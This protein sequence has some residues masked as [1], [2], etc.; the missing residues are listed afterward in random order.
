MT[1]EEIAD[2]DG[3]LRRIPPLHQP[4]HDQSMSGPD[5][6]ASLRPPSSA[7]SLR[8]GERGLSFHLQSSLELAG[9]PLSYGCPPGEPG[10]AVVRI[11][12]ARIR[13]LG[14]E[15]VA[16]GVP[17]HVLVLGLADRSRS[18]QRRLQKD[19]AKSAR[20]I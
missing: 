15:I 2:S 6:R 7:F 8:P 11:E 4:V 20:Y 14:L 13:A 9:E 5:G 3:L 12:A 1:G 16:D 10:W 18:E 19:L 17:H